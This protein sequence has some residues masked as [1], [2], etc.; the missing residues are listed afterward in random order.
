VCVLQVVIGTALAAER[1]RRVLG[2]TEVQPADPAGFA[3]AGV[4]HVLAAAPARPRSGAGQLGH[5]HALALLV[6]MP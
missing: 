5:E 3:L 2:V 4:N 1:T 6:R